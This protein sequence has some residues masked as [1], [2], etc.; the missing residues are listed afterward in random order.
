MEARASTIARPAR[1][2][3]A[4][5]LDTSTPES[6]LFSAYGLVPPEKTLPCLC[7]GEVTAD[8][9]CPAAGVREH[10][11]TEQHREWRR[12]FGL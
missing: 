9:E 5:P 8:V 12:R 6:A 3:S 2:L 1:D 7:G 4:Y 10:Q 11:R